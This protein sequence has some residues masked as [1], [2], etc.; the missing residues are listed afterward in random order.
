LQPVQKIIFSIPQDLFSLS[1]WEKFLYL[2]L[3]AFEQQQ[4]ILPLLKDSFFAQAI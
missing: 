1:S 2:V 4:P 3:F